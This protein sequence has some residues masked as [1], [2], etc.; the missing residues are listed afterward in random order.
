MPL[1]KNVE[2]KIFLNIWISILVGIIP[3]CRTYLCI[4][5][6]HSARTTETNL[7]LD[8]VGFFGGVSFF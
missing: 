7:C 2:F 5:Y 3:P 4:F 8:K 6:E 1:L